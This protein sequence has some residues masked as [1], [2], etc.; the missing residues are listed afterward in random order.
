MNQARPQPVDPIAWCCA[1]TLVFLALAAVRLTIPST[2]YFD[3]VHYLPAAREL[4]VLGNYTNREHPLLG[5]ELIALGI[6]LFGDN[7]LGWRVMPL[8]G[9]CLAM[10]ASMR[11]LWFATLDRGATV[12]FGILLATGFHFFVQSRIAMLDIFYIAFLAAAYWHCAAAMR[13]PEHGR[14]CLAIAGAF[15]GLAM[16]SKWNAIPLAIVPGIAFLVLRWRAGRRRLL[17]SRRGA[18]VPGITLLEAA[19]WLGVL[20]LAIYALT[21]APAYFFASQAIGSSGGA[22][23]LLHLQQDMLALH[24]DVIKAHPYQSTWPQW[25]LN[26]RAIWYLYEVADGAQRGIMLIGNPLTMILGLIALLWCA[27]RAIVQREPV[28]GALVGLYVLSLGFWIVAEKPV[29]FYYHYALPTMFLLAALALALGRL[30]SAR[31]YWVVVLTVGGSVALF[32]FYFP[33][34]SAAP[35]DGDLAF[36]RWTWLASWR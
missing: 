11:A 35:L 14:R 20:P 28:C 17:V 21:F 36:Q 13:E 32:V 5:K 30:W 2:P 3:E 4:L 16:A 12:F 15:L 26:S 7:A 8:I 10:F 6:A 29:Q 34:L 18:P 19:L 1:L 23:S 24:A 22:Q 33:I 27:L 31:R 9:G 25:M